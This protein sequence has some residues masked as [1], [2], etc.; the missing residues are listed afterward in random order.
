MSRNAREMEQLLDDCTAHV[1]ESERAAL[2]A[3]IV[4]LTLEYAR[5]RRLLE[6]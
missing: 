3:E 1:P 4:K 6:D 2:K 5:Q